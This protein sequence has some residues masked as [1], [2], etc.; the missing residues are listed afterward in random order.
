GATLG[1]EPL[2]W[3][4]LANTN[5]PI[6]RT[7]DRFGH[8]IDE[9]EFHPVWHELLRLAVHHEL[10]GLPWRDPRPGPT[11]ARAALFYVLAQAEAGHGCPISMTYSAVPALRAQPELAAE[12]EPRFTSTHY[13]ARFVP[14]GQKT[15]ALCGM[16]M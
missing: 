5:P 8:R 15:G 3:G 14:A 11:A 1:G 9:V 16:A 13:D 12:W 6:L 10:H 7:H 2:T 4:R